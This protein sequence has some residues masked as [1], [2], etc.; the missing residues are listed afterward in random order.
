MVEP[1]AV[2][3]EGRDGA[4]DLC[5]EREYEATT[6]QVWDMITVPSRVADWFTEAEVELRVGGR[7][8][9]RGVCEAA[10]E[11]LACEPPTSLVWTWPHP[12]HPRSQ[13]RWT[14]ASAPRRARLTLVQTDL[15]QPELLSIAAGWHTHL[16]ALPAALR[17]VRTPFDSRIARRHGAHYLSALPA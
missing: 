14:L 12:A 17:G 11:V 2:A 9:L 4:Y 6:R 13:V 10:G 15:R 7:I 3:I 1:Y 16:D 5:F 8:I